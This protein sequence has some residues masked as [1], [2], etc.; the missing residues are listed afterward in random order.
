MLRDSGGVYERLASPLGVVVREA[1]SVRFGVY[2]DDDIRRLSVVEVRSAEQRDALNRPLPGGLY[3]PKM[4]PTDHYSSCPTCGLDYTLCPGHLGRIELALPVYLPV[5]FGTLKDLLRGTCLFCH[6]F[7][8]PSAKL[9]PL[10]DAL[11]LMD[12]GLLVDAATMLDNGAD[13]AAGGGGA[14]DGAEDGA[15]D[16]DD[17]EAAE[18]MRGRRRRGEGASRG[19]LSEA[20]RAV[21]ERAQR[22]HLP[23]P[24]LSAA[25]RSP[26]IN[27]L[28][29]QTLSRFYRSLA[30]SRKCASCGKHSPTIRHE[31]GCKLFCA[32]LPR[33]LQEANAAI[34][35][36]RGGAGDSEEDEDADVAMSLATATAATNGAEDEHGGEDGSDA[37]EED[38]ED[39][40][41]DDDE[42]AAP[43][44]ATAKTA[45]KTAPRPNGAPRRAPRAEDAAAVD[46]GSGDGDD[47]DDDDGGGGGGGANSGGQPGS[48]GA[49]PSKD[50]RLVFISP[51]DAQRHL[52]QMWK[53]E[54]DLLARLYRGLNAQ[55]FF[56]RVV[57]VPPS[58]FRP[59]STVGDGVFE[60]A[61][62]VL[63][64]RV[65]A[66]DMELRR[67][68]SGQP[69]YNPAAAGAA[70]ATATAGAPP[71]TERVLKAWEELC[72]SVQA[73]TDSS[74]NAK[75]GSDREPAGV[76]LTLGCEADPWL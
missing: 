30:A 11:A 35:A 31:S 52:E 49:K 65:L 51:S 5:L 50:V 71:D 73:L 36:A 2:S 4:G 37:D 9:A 67:H 59:P 21:L 28:R 26:H 27:T 29:K 32:K 41:E 64:G 3:D 15:E 44:G 48:T 23:T 19:E 74:K 6:K 72:K 33:K 58:R 10:V 7:R 66:Q 70:A 69:R 56:Q 53:R 13:A 54:G 22:A 55:S 62:N 20:A 34:S 1:A 16:G 63:L 61:S 40:D 18:L 24:P 38:E 45:P 75:S 68:L 47:D 60:P 43:R 14:N 12:A 8:T 46:E 25:S 17:Q 76:K 42:D 39:D 57:P